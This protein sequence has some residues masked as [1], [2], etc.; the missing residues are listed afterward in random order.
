MKTTINIKR[1]LLNYK[2][3][4]LSNILKILRLFVCILLVPLVS[5]ANSPN[6]S[7]LDFRNNKNCIAT[8]NP[9]LL[10][11]SFQKVDNTDGTV[12]FESPSFFQIDE[13]GNFIKQFSL[14]GNHWEGDYRGVCNYI[15]MK[16]VINSAF[17]PSEVILENYIFNASFI[18]FTREGRI[19]R[20]AEIQNPRYRVA[21]IT[22]VK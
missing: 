13:F 5:N 22:C 11:C 21:R 4:S 8:S 9:S 18:T 1:A 16:H 7:K 10:F 2:H 15:N 14:D 17:T 6:E 3:Y 19:T 12:L 20:M